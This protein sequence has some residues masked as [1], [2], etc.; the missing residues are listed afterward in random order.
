MD[1]AETALRQVAS[2]G[3]ANRPARSGGPIRGTTGRDS[4]KRSDRH[5]RI[6]RDLCAR[7]EVQRRRLI[8]PRVP[9]YVAATWFVSFVG[10]GGLL[11]FLD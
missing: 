10:T 8:M 3:T 1:A 6:G 2:V 9:F 5:R 11:C 7:A 4:V